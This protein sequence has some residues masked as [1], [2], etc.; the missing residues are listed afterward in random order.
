MHPTPVLTTR[1]LLIAL[2][3]LLQKLIPILQRDD[4]IDLCIRALD[5]VQIRRHDLLA[6]DSLQLDRV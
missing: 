3:C 6:R 5:V 4:G 1:E 2:Y